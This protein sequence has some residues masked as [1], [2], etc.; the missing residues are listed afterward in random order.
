MESSRK[1]KAGIMMKEYKFYGWETAEVSAVNEESG[2]FYDVQTFKPLS[3][4]NNF[5]RSLLSLNSNISSLLVLKI[6]A[7][8]LDKLYKRDKKD[9]RY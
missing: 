5:S 6:S 9:I 1:D 7:Y 8:L 2:Y 4:S 3:E